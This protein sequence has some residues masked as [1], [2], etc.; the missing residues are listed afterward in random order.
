ME[1]IGGE[2]EDEECDDDAE[3]DEILSEGWNS[4]CIEAGG[5]SLFF[6]R[7]KR[8]ESFSGLRSHAEFG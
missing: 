7:V 8:F 3:S 5:L 6:R 1:V 4:G 2:S